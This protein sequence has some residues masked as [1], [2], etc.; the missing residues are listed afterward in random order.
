MCIVQLLLV[1]NLTAEYSTLD[2]GYHV[3]AEVSTY[4]QKKDA[5]G[6]PSEA[7]N[8]VNFFFYKPISLQSQEESQSDELVE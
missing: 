6:E 3:R 8:Q 2:G 4:E 1:L 7:V 5:D